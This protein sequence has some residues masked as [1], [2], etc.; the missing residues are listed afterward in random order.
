MTLEEL[1]KYNGKGQP[2][3][4]VVGGTIYDVSDS[5]LWKDG[6]HEQIHQ[7]GCDLTEELRTAPHVAAVIQRFPT[8]GRLEEPPVV[9]STSGAKPGI[10]AAVVIVLILAWLLLR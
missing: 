6:T 2:A 9:K 3:Y 5:P 7:A 10:A 8:V 4:V 1:S